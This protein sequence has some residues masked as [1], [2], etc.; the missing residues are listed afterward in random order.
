[1]NRDSRVNLCLRLKQDFISNLGLSCLKWNK[2]TNR[3]SK[4]QPPTSS[5]VPLYYIYQ[6][7]IKAPNV[8]IFRKPLLGLGSQ[9]QAKSI[10]F[11]KKKSFLSSLSFFSHHGMDDGFPSEFWL[12]LTPPNYIPLFSVKTENPTRDFSQWGVLLV[13]LGFLI[14]R[15]AQNL[16]IEFS[17][18]IW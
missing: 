17:M 18:E 1:M 13:V 6:I 5:L 7:I 4:W 8:L 11:K 2:N 3:E 14:K 16:L 10:F 9:N 12:T 15:S